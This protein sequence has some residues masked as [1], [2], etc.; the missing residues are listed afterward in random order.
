MNEL[1][2]LEKIYGTVLREGGATEEVDHFYEHSAVPKKLDEQEQVLRD[3][4]KDAKR[5]LLKVDKSQLAYNSSSGI[6]KNGIFSFSKE[7]TLPFDTCIF[8]FEKPLVIKWRAFDSENEYIDTKLLAL[9]IKRLDQGHDGTEAKILDAESITVTKYRAFLLIDENIEDNR[10]EVL[11]LGNQYIEFYVIWKEGFTLTTIVHYNHI[12][13]Q[14]PTLCA[15]SGAITPEEKEKAYFCQEILA[16]DS[17]VETLF[18]LVDK[19]N[20]S[21]AIYRKKKNKGWYDFSQTPNPKLW[22]WPFTK[23][24]LPK[25]NYTYVLDGT[26]YVYDKED[27]ALGTGTPHRY[28]YD[29]RRHPRLIGDKI[30]WVNPYQRGRGSYIP[31]IYTNRGTWFI[32]YFFYLSERLTKY[33]IVEILIIRLIRLFRK[34][35]AIKKDK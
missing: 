33:R 7:L 11:H 1:N 2:T 24:N 23:G 32:Q 4:L 10:N 18:S 28:R 8:A 3:Y 31:K 15:F 22:G 26:H 13:C 9:L 20:N 27:I 5:F 14:N 25:D 17:L 16:R 34:V 21:E 35:T 12:P 29:V 19:I 6:T 30:V